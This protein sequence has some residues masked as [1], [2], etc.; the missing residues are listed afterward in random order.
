MVVHLYGSQEV[1]VR[2]PVESENFCPYFKNSLDFHVLD[3][4]S[5]PASMALRRESSWEADVTRIGS[6]PAGA[7]A[8]R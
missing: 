2:V 6:P 1:R 4:V 3:M 5:R 7:I 8:D